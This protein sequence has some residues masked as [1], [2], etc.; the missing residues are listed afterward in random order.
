MEKYEKNIE[1]VKI[2]A[3]YEFF[4]VMYYSKSG[5]SFE[6]FTEII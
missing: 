1:I 2:V 3:T 5:K 4:W 6:L